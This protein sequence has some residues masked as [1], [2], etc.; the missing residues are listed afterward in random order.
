MNQVVP[1]AIVLL[2][3][4]SVQAGSVTIIDAS[5]DA[6]V[7]AIPVPADR[8]DLVAINITEQPTELSVA[9]SVANMGQAAYE[10]RL[11]LPLQIG[12]EHWRVTVGIPPDGVGRQPFATFEWLDSGGIRIESRGLSPPVLSG[13]QVTVRI[14]R[15][16]LVNSAG[17]QPAVGA[18]L[19]AGP[20]EAILQSTSSRESADLAPDDGTSRAMTFDL[21]GLVVGDVKLAIEPLGQFSNGEAAIHSYRLHL[22]NV[23]RSVEAINLTLQPGVGTDAILERDA[24]RLGI[25]QN[26]TLV[27]WILMPF[28]HQHA[29][30]VDAMLTVRTT[31]DVEAIPLRVRFADYPQPTGHHPEVWLHSMASEEQEVN[32]AGQ[33]TAFWSTLQDDPRGSGAAVAPN[34][35]SGGISGNSVFSWEFRYSPDLVLDI[36]T[37]GSGNGSVRLEL[38]PEV[39]F[40][41]AAL[42]VEVRLRDE[43]GT[44]ANVGQTQV[45]METSLASLGD[46]EAGDM[47]SVELPL[48]AVDP[49]LIDA[50]PG[51][52]L[53][54]HVDLH[55]GPSPLIGPSAP[56][57]LIHLGAGAMVAMP[58]RDVQY[59]DPAP[60]TGVFRAATLPS[61]W[62][63]DGRPYPLDLTEGV[64]DW[65]AAGPHAGWLAFDPEAGT[66]AI[67]AP[68][69]VVNGTRFVAAIVASSDGIR[70]LL[71]V[72]GSVAGH[73]DG[74]RAEE[75]AV[76]AEETTPF[77]TVAV[78]AVVMLMMLRRR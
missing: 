59:S 64:N 76:P 60:P 36:D 72:V 48:R 6:R 66:L 28:Q 38:H 37:R 27:A 16:Y 70:S 51:Y 3:V 8:L 55:H 31:D 23:G 49:R 42:Q 22:R 9:F 62:H 1:L 50:Q 73:S 69:G 10:T 61:N 47:V 12:L 46:L 21:D 41:N 71:P 26:Q 68:D 7:G 30:N 40:T 78:L 45:V 13:D 75:V 20:A 58:L 17:V 63:T 33:Q 35:A 74:V 18:V 29:A 44:P 43:A 54:F 39:A 24:L 15:E 25:G 77:P 67:H 65:A 56:P 52:N 57:P 19:H 53:W 4:S 11:R 2:A 34:R 5:G 14:P 32:V